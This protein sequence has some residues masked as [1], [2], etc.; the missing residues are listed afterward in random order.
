MG[1]DEDGHEEVPTLAECIH[2]RKH[3]LIDIIQLQRTGRW[4]MTEEIATIMV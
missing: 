1:E 4:K 3:E 2:G